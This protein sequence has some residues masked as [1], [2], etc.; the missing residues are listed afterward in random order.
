VSK[1]TVTELEVLFTADTSRVDKAA[2]S[3]K[4]QADKIEKRPVELEVDGDAK[5]ALDAMDRVEA[6][7]KKIVSQKTALTIN[8][9]IDRAESSLSKVQEKLD[10]LHSVEATMEVTAD[11]KRAESALQQI[12]RRRDALVSAR[13]T[14]EVD[15]NEGQAKQKLQDVADFAGEAGEDGGDSAGA[16]LVG[17]IVAAL[18]TIP[19]A[20]AIVGI[21]KT[22]AGAVVE[23]FQDGLA[24]EVRQDRLQALTGISEQDAARFAMA[25]GEAY[26]NVFGE[27]IESNMDTARLALQSGLIDPTETVRDSQK[28]IQSLA[29]IADV[30]DEDVQPVA[31]AVT[32]LLSSGLVKSADEAFDLIAAG[33]REGVNLHEDLLDTLIEYPALFARLGLSGEDALGLMNQGLEAGARNSDL[34]ADALKEFQIRASEDLPNATVGFEALGMSVEESMAKV[35]AGG[36]PARDVLAQVLNELGEMEPGVERTAAA[37]ALFGT[38]AEDLGDALFNMDLDTAV[39]SLNGVSGA[40]Q[41]MFDTLADN[42]ATKLEE[43]KR[44]IDVAVQ[45][46]Q[47][48]LAGAFAD[49]LAEGAEWISSNR[50]PLL[51]FFADLANGAIDFGIAAVEGAAGATEGFGT[52]VSGPLADTVDGIAGVLDGLSGLPFVDLGDEVE[53]LE[54][55]ADGMRDFDDTTAGAADELRQALIPGLEEARSGFNDF[56]DPQ[57]AMG[58]LHDATLRLAGAVAEVGYAA[59]GSQISMENLDAANLSATEGGRQL[60]DQILAAVDALNAEAAAGAVAGD[61]QATLTE[62]YAAGRQALIDQ[63]VQMGIAETDA[64][65]LAD[66][67]NAVPGNVDTIIASNAAAQTSTIEDLGYAIETLPDGSVKIVAN[68]DDAQLSVDRFVRDNQNRTIRVTVRADGSTS[69][70]TGAGNTRFERDGDVL[71]PMAGGGVLSP[72]APIAQ[73]VNP[74]TWRVVG[75]R[76]DVPELYAP[77]DGSPRSWALI[78]EGIRRMGGMPMQDGGVVGSTAYAGPGQIT[79]PLVQVGTVVQGTPTDVGHEVRLA[80]LGVM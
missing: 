69:G 72:M 56:I 6:E 9:N 77:L 21:A 48:A 70:F 29:G 53:G 49:P 15:V 2:K 65:A 25:A 12:Q 13:A 23:G 45:G 31:R 54:A 75:D 43:A 76:M 62:R 7:A 32:T 34:A 80:L 8:A 36:E 71:L 50:G 4:D 79:G 17:G 5:G 52:F 11:I 16:G 42:D 10:Y 46:I 40:A 30:L 24:V 63:L 20:G 44:N 74:N 28:V 26:A 78:M 19:I 58:H 35:A 1:A 37:M 27:S 33:A 41:A 61:S 39:D 18:A 14:M 22:V 66:A 59:D 57:I 68:T 47:G 67:Y 51:A 73:V 3:V 55:L 64:I 38:Q 60:E